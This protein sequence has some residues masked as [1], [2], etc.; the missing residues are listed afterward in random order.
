M[1]TKA[2]VGYLLEISDHW[3]CVCQW[4][5]NFWWVAGGPGG[6]FQ[7]TK[8]LKSLGLWVFWGRV[9][10]EDYLM[11]QYAFFMHVTRTFEAFENIVMQ[12]NNTFWVQKRTCS[13]GLEVVL[14]DTIAS[15]LKIRHQHITG[16]MTSAVLAKHSWIQVKCYPLLRLLRCSPWGERGRAVCMFHWVSCGCP[17]QALPASVTFGLTFK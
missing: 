14:A 2:I 12:G 13:L 8:E 10:M 15:N 5:I 11:G 4:W 9:Y 16:A 1:W 7:D 6:G 17:G 3:Q